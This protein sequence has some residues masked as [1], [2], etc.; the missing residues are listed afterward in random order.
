MV[1]VISIPA[2]TDCCFS[3]KGLNKGLFGPRGPTGLLI[4]TLAELGAITGLMVVV[5]VV[6]VVVVM[7]VVM[8][9]V[10]VV[11]LVVVA[12]VVLDE[13]SLESCRVNSGRCWWSSFI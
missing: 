7:V 8:V 3:C 13:M 9:M 1:L 5:V 12:V 4:M 11:M 10:V 6:V 2:P